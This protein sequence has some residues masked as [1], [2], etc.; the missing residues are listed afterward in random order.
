V[1]GDYVRS[2]EEGFDLRL[3]NQ[4]EFN[5]LLELLNPKAAKKIA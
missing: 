5:A 2:K 3:I 4:Y 1:A